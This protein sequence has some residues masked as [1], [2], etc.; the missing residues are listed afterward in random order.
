MHGINPCVYACMWILYHIAAADI[1]VVLCGDY[2]QALVCPVITSSLLL[3]VVIVLWFF[4]MCMY[5]CIMKLCMY[6]YT[7]TPHAT[8]YTYTT[9]CTSQ[10]NV[11]EALSPLS[12][13]TKNCAKSRSRSRGMSPTINAP[14]AGISAYFPT[15]Y[16][17]I[18]ESDITIFANIHVSNI[19]YNFALLLS[20]FLITFYPHI[21]LYIP[22]R[23]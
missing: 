14:D 21:R 8:P 23:M 9:S 2:T 4:L 19:S 18:D 7:T 22:L 13:S 5:V 15:P 12:T 3:S 11:P 17:Y 1:V 20:L 6:V 10:Y 16:R